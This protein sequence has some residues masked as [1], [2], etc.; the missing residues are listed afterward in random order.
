MKYKALSEQYEAS[1]KSLTVSMPLSAVLFVIAG[2]WQLIK[3]IDSIFW[4]SFIFFGIAAIVIVMYFILRK[5]LRRKIAE[6]KEWEKQHFK[7][8]P[9]Q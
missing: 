2:I 9:E 3:Y 6:S 4:I 8:E 1:L 7:D 5:Y